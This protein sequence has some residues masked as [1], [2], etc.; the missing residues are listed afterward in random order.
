MK[1]LNRLMSGTAP[2][3]I[4]VANEKGGQGKSLNGLAVAD[5]AHLCNVH[6]GVAQIDSQ[7]R[8]AKAI[9]RKVLTIDAVA[10]NARRNPAAE[11]RM[12][13]P[14]HGFL[15]KAAKSKANILLDVGAN[16]AQRLA[17]W[18][19]L[20]DLQEDLDSWNFETILAIPYVA[21]AEGIRQAGKTALLL[22]EHLPRAH[23]VLIENERDGHFGDLHPSSDAAQAYR[24]CIAPLKA[25]AT[26]LTMPAIE[27]GSW[28]LFE[29]SN[30][31]LMTVAAMPV[32]KVM[33][34]TGLPRPEAKVARGDVAGWA[35]A[36]FAELDRVLPWNKEEIGHE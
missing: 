13:T 22:C 32:E 21:E 7:A 12:F 20:V 15:E 1:Y 8:L 16:Q 3:F 17:A 35:G 4:I 31:R 10:G 36:F 6:L 27:A 28:R 34:L 24:D 14:L 19:G 5:Y 2:L 9:G 23:L 33:S 25:E 11:M 30:A 18:S 29:A 26:L